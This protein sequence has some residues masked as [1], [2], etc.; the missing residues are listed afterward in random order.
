MRRGLTTAAIGS[1]NAGGQSVFVRRLSGHLAELGWAIDV[2]TSQFGRPETCSTL[3]EDVLV[4]RIA[5]GHEGAKPRVQM[6]EDVAG[7]YL[8]Y[9]KALGRPNGYDVVFACYYQSVPSGLALGSHFR[10]RTCIKFA[11]LG[12]L[13]VL[14]GA[15]SIDP[16]RHRVETDACSGFDAIVANSEA[17]KSI[18][19]EHYQASGD[20]IHVIP[21]GVDLDRF[22]TATS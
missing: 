3:A 17:E 11:S 21:N 1:P 14:A 2:F 8:T 7:E 12:M 10:A 19:M 20:K 6:F 4:H 13:K 5:L 18:L 16:D 15:G 9:A 22:L